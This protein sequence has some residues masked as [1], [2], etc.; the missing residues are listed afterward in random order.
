L[1]LLF[2]QDGEPV[3]Y[4]T[5]TDGDGRT[6][7]ERVTGPMGG[8]VQGAPRRPSFGEGGQGGGGYGDDF[9]GGRY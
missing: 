1:Y 5:T 8:F 2:Q 3:E 9:G 6:R 4:T 7:A